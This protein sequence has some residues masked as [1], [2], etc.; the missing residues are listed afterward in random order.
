MINLARYEL[1]KKKHGNYA[2]WAIWS[3]PGERPK[4]KT[5]DMSVFDMDENRDL[6]ASLNPNIVMVALNFSRPVEPEIFRNF[7]DG[8]PWANDFKIRYAFAGTPYYGAYM[9]DVIK[10][11]PEVKSKKVMGHLKADPSIIQRNIEILRDEIMDLGVRE[12]TIL[13]FGKDTHELLAR[14]LRADEYKD[15]VRVTHYSHQI[16]KEQYREKVLM[17]I[18]QALCSNQSPSEFLKSSC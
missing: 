13:A 11:L 17:Q 15:L 16:G 10:N 3:P 4:S 1:I 7:H 6:L 9:T 12:P 2:S 14:H 5:G 18:Q 8:S